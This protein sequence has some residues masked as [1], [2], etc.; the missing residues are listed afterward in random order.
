MGAMS[1]IWIWILAQTDAFMGAAGWVRAMV[2]AHG[3]W[4]WERSKLLVALREG[5]L[6]RL[7]L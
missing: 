4:D 2:L 5:V 3:E 6:S 1:L 7:I